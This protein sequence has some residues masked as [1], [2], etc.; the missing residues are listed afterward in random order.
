MEVSPYT[1][2]R[3]TFNI[4]SSSSV[5]FSNFV[6]FYLFFLTIN[7]FPNG[8]LSIEKGICPTGTSFYV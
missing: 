8:I 3:F 7:K 5:K 1:F 4:F 6:T 2:T